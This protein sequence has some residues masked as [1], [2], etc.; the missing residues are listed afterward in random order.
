[1]RI[2]VFLLVWSGILC[3]GIVQAYVEDSPSLIENEELT[4]S[5]ID[6]SMIHSDGR[7]MVLQS[8]DKVYIEDIQRLHHVDNYFISYDG[9]IYRLSYAAMSSMVFLC[10]NPI[11]RTLL[12]VLIESVLCSDRLGGTD[13]NDDG[14]IDKDEVNRE[15]NEEKNEAVRVMREAAIE[16][17][18]DEWE[19]YDQRLDE[20]EL[21]ILGCSM[22]DDGGTQCPV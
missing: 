8:R 18:F 21:Q 14:I 20:P 22:T 19:E 7:F 9:N 16:D 4:I 2:I 5:I 1:M 12:G 6:I 13:Y 15:L 11:N 10:S 3:T 17:M